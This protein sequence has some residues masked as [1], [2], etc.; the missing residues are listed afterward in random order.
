MNQTPEKRENM[1]RF[2]TGKEAELAMA[3]LQL[4]QR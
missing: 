2:S 3:E 4:P 1:H